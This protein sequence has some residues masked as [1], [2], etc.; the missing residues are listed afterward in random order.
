MK[1]KHLHMHAKSKIN[2]FRLNYFVILILALS[3]INH[4]ICGDC[5]SESKISDSSTCFN[6]IIKLS[7]WDR[8]GQITVRNDGILLIE[9]S[10]AGDRIF[11]G[12]NKNGRGYFSNEAV[13]KR[14]SN[15]PQHW[16]PTGDS[17]G[18]FESKNMLVS[19]YSDTSK[20]KQYIL[21]ISSFHALSELHDIDIDHDQYTVWSTAKFLKFTDESKYFFSHQF[22]LFQSTNKNIYYAAYVQYRDTNDKDEAYS[23]SY[24]LSRFYFTS[25]T[26][27]EMLTKEFDV[28]YD[29]RIVSAFYMDKYNPHQFVIFFVKKGTTSYYMRTHNVDDLEFVEGKEKWIDNLKDNN[30]DNGYPGYGIFFKALYLSYEYAAFIYFT[31]R[32]DG[33]S[34]KFKILYINSDFSWSAKKSKDISSY[35]FDTSITMN[36]FY[37]IDEERL[38]FVST[39]GKTSLVLMFFDTF[40]WYK[41]LKI[42]TYKFALDGYKFNM[43]FSVGYYNDF[44]V[45]TSTIQH[46]N[47]DQFFSSLFFF[48]YPNGTDF[49]MNISPYVMASE[50]YNNKNLI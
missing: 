49:Y 32:D 31:C 35:S 26:N 25:L 30:G 14:I 4:C 34:L 1:A 43:E 41:H 37:K 39:I 21:S 9:Y 17:N 18:R 47:S 40:D 36:E 11:Y 16:T 10:N 45:L 7:T 38:L 15:L 28:N 20:S 8:A 48:S 22:S 50:Y 23:V 13:F 24:T 33:T 27:Y 46:S 5:N 3:Q 12:L 2:F 19:L 29:N 42:R 44:L 6:E